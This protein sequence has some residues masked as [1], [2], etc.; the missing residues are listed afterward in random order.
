[1]VKEST[2]PFQRSPSQSCR[3]H[4]R[5][6]WSWKI[7]PVHTRHWCGSK[8]GRWSR[9]FISMEAAK[10]LVADNTFVEALISHFW[11]FQFFYVVHLNWFFYDTHYKICIYD[12]CVLCNFF[13]TII[14]RI[15]I[16]DDD[17][18]KDNNNNNNNRVCTLGKYNNINIGLIIHSGYLCSAS[19]SL[20]LL[21]GAPD[22]A[23]ILCR[24][25][26]PK[27]DKQLWVKDCPRSLR[28]S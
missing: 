9:I 28:G 23:W 8:A 25:F 10:M 14:I 27:R 3:R 17:I 16:A 4:G 20:L 26:T 18:D 12:V 19:S 5:G 13:V 11:G 21:G 15:E 1:V 7:F 2:S 6:S 22:T 24:S